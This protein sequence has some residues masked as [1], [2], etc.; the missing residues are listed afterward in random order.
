MLKKIILYTT[1]TIS[2]FVAGL[3]ATGYKYVITAFSRTWMIGNSTANINDAADFKT[4]TIKATTAQPWRKH[5][6]YN[7]IAL[8][9]ELEAHLKAYRSA[10]FLVIHKGEILNE[11]YFN[12]YDEKSKT[13]AFSATKTILTM[14]VG[15]AIKDGYIKSF[16]QPIVDF[17]PELANDELAQK[18]T[19]AQLSAMTSGYAWDEAYYSAFSPTVKLLYGDDS[20]QLVLSGRFDTLPGSEFYYSSAS[21]QLL[22][23]A[24]QR[25]I[26]QHQSDVTLSDYLSAKF[27]QPLGMNDDAMWHLDNS[28]MELA[29]CCVNSN[30]RNFAKLGQLLLNNGQWRGQ[31]LIAR[32]FVQN[33]HNAAKDPYYGLSTWQ[34]VE[35][36]PRY[37]SMVGHLG[38]YIISV[39]D[40]QLLIVRL[41]E[42]WPS[43][44]EFKTI[45]LPFL[46]KQSVL[47]I[48]TLETK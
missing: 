18:A 27:W 25:A 37:H 38:Q 19:L 8:P 44:E 31:Q 35:H 40:H 36:S 48:E 7:T 33:M 2:L 23:I 46:V 3:Y 29:Y 10:A 16:D 39:P 17:L 26:Q 45:E 41:G 15:A 11:H 47:M 42:T 9:A 32:S 24:L 34:S 5:S 12:G 6:L 28:G 43:N 20:N 22:G 1:L 30:A 4:R 13:N 14:L 21:T